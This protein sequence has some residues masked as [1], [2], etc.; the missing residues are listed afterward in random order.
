MGETSAGV[1]EGVKGAVSVELLY[2]HGLD[3]ETE[4]HTRVLDGVH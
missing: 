4:R 3:D 2:K 1:E